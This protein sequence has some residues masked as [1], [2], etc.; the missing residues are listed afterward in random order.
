MTMEKTVPAEVRD[1]RKGKEANH[2]MTFS[3]ELQM[4]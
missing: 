2:I 4:V 3:R 1:K